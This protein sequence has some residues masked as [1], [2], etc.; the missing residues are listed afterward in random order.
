MDWFKSKLKRKRH[1]AMAQPIPFTIP[2]HPV[3]EEERLRDAPAEHA[4]AILSVL[5]VLQLLHDRGVLNL[6]RGMLAAG[7]EL[8]DIVTAS[9]NT[10]ESI[11]SIRNVLLLGKLLGSLPPEAVQSMLEAVTSATSRPAGQNPP[12]ILELFRRM[13]TENSRRGLA[14][15][16]DVLEGFGRGIQAVPA[17]VKDQQ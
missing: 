3:R 5:E 11:R 9:L 1:R 12:G 7:G 8:V 17:V 2:G 6:V 15:V 13:R 10:P 4:G 14:V 16:L